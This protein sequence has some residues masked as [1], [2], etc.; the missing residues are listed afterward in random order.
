[1]LKPFKKQKYITLADQKYNTIL[2]LNL[3]NENQIKYF[4]EV[5]FF[6]F[7]KEIAICL[8][9]AIIVKSCTKIFFII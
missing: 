2:Y 4:F 9:I 8:N 5:F 7:L 1:M 6:L 3:E